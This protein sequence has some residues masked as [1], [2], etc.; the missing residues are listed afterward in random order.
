MPDSTAELIFKLWQVMVPDT[1]VQVIICI[2]LE[3]DMDSANDCGVRA[4]VV[5]PGVEE[6]RMRE[7]GYV[8]ALR[9]IVP[10]PSRNSM[11]VSFEIPKEADANLSLYDV[12]GRLVATL[13]NER[14]K[15]GVK[16]AT[17]NGDL[18]PSGIYYCVLR[19]GGLSEA[20]K[21]IWLK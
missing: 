20:R 7:R 6:A 5:K 10:N 11:T 3:S 13:V 1:T 9:S 17:W 12:A 15:P 8:F 21:V 19:A 14:L 2:V 18:M 4:T 16:S